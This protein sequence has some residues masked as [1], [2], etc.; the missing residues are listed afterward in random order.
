MNHILFLDDDPIRH[1]R[2]AK[3][4]EGK[5]ITVDHVRTAQEAITKLDSALAEGSKY[6]LVCLDHDLG[7]ETF[8]E[9]SDPRG[10]GQTVAA[11]IASNPKFA[12]VI[13]Q[14]IIH[15]F[16]VSGGAVM[17]RTLYPTGILVE[18]VPFGMWNLR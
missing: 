14:I 9:S 12:D 15:S 8:Q 13:E 10:T 1:A 4:A 6:H 11:H 2:F 18:K 7:G 5:S 3:M 17:L 16:N